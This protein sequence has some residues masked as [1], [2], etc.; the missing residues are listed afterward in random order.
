MY[1]SVELHTDAETV[2]LPARNISLGGAYLSGDGHDL[3]M[4]EVGMELEVL[5]FDALNEQRT[6]VRLV[7]EILRHDGDGLALM[8]AD[9]DPD[10]A[11]RVAQ[12]LEQLQPRTP[13]HE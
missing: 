11:L 5:V 6:P 7:G 3:G 2:V 12:L 8:W 1:A 9:S 13:D 4:F 10:I